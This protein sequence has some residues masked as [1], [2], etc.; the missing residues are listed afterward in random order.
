MGI[1]AMPLYV[2]MGFT[3]LE[4]AS[5]SKLYGLI[6]TLVGGLAGGALSIRFGV[7]R[8]M[9]L[10]AVLSAATNLLFVWL[11]HQGHD[12]QALMVVI[13]ADNFAS[14]LAA[15]A[16]IAY[17]S[18]LTNIAYSATQYAIF[19]SIMLLLPKWVGGFSGRFVDAF[20]YDA[21]FF[22]TAC[23]GIPVVGLLWAANKYVN[24]KAN[25]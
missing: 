13:S 17:L 8:I 11:R 3:K 23:I 10:G 16:F 12:V 18:G 20:G 22:S 14:G 25:A 4:V 21:F 9:M 24:P 15:A 7:M 19:S 6:M 2:D 1:M 5:V